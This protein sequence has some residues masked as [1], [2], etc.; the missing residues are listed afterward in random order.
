MAPSSNEP[1]AACPLRLRRALSASKP[2]L[3]TNGEP[4][5]ENT[6][7]AALHRLGCDRTVIT[8]HGL[9]TMASTM[10]QKCGG[11]SDVIGR[12]LSHA[13]SNAVKATH[14]HVEHL[15]V[16]RKMTQAW[17]D[18]LEGLRKSGEIVPLRA[19]SHDWCSPAP[20][21][22]AVAPRYSAP[23]RQFRISYQLAGP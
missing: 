2:A 10:L 20:Q 1:A 3:R 7:N 19:G 22:C 12:Q 4:P 13:E 21:D 5:S 16:R 14:N 11:P 15:P 6:I 17:T 18:H 23:P 9:R 8:A